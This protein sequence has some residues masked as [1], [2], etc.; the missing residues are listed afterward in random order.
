MSHSRFSHFAVALAILAVGAGSAWAQQP[1]Q[2]TGS[3][4]NETSGAYFYY[5]A[6]AT[7]GTYMYTFGGYQTGAGNSSGDAY[8][9]CRRYDVVNNTWTTLADLPTQVYLNSG[10]F[11]NGSLYSF[12]N[13]YYGNGAIYRYVIASN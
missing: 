11:Y 10:A 8:R 2:P 6:I 1:E 7:D 13:G 5:G 3:W 4:A 12:G 9:V